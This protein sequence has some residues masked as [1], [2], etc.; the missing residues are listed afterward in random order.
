VG[1]RCDVPTPKDSEAVLIHRFPLRVFGMLISHFG[2]LKSLAGQFL[3]GLAILLV[4]GYR[5][6]SMSEC[7]KVV[8]LGRSLMLLEM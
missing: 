2:V 4:M 5:R 6:T 7:G 1:L 3:P 8:Q